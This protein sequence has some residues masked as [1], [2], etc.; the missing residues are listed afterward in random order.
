M[1]EE[2]EEDKVERREMRITH[3]FNI[4]VRWGF[5]VWMEG[6]E[7]GGKEK[8]KTCGSKERGRI[9]WVL[10]R[11]LRNWRRKGTLAFKLNISRVSAEKEVQQQQSSSHGS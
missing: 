3:S 8:E 5:S 1:E 11:F 6:K 9:L 2:S 7:W 10:F 4:S